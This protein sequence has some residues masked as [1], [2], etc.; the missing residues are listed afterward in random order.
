MD[1][2]PAIDRESLFSWNRG[3]LWTKDKPP[4]E[5]ACDKLE[6]AQASRPDP[7]AQ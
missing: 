3:E 2:R 7:S 5:Y 6:A 1:S 4:F